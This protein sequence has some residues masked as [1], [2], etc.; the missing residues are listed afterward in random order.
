MYIVIYENK[1]CSKGSSFWHA[2]LRKIFEAIDGLKL[3]TAGGD[4]TARIWTLRSR[5]LICEACHRPGCNLTSQE[6]RAQYR[7]GCQDDDDDD[8][9]AAITRR[10]ARRF[11]FCPK[12]FDILYL[13]HGP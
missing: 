2:S 12:W 3:A 10:K 7:Q 8:D 11:G 13:F 9:N 5:D 1:S 6:W 4:S